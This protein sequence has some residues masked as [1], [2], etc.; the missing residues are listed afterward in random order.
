MYRYVCISYMYAGRVKLDSPLNLIQVTSGKLQRRYDAAAVYCYY[1]CSVTAYVYIRFFS[2]TAVVWRTL[3]L[4]ATFF[5][6]RLTRERK[7]DSLMMYIRR[8]TTIWCLDTAVCGENK[9]RR[10]L[11]QQYLNLSTAVYGSWLATNGFEI[12]ISGWTPS[13]RREMLATVLLLLYYMIYL[14]F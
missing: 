9:R 5:N 10:R 11:Q 7:A 2:S 8:S 13:H 12:S 14:C 3:W 4:F 6:P 1:W